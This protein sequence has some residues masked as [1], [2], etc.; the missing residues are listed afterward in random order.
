MNKLLLFGAFAAFAA[1]AGATG[2]HGGG[3][4]SG[5]Y[6]GSGS[7]GRAGPA[8]GTHIGSS[9]GTRLA[10]LGVESFDRATIDGHET[11]VATVKLSTPLTDGERKEI[12][13]HGYK[14]YK[15]EYLPRT[16][17]DF[18][19]PTLPAETWCPDT[20]LSRLSIPRCIDFV[21]GAAPK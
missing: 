12:L 16:K 19:A 9:L 6:G 4:G 17:K 5:H 20:L 3:G 21:T 2:G 10:R 11:L 18:L 7:A 1:G 8:I 15:K 14:P 13:D